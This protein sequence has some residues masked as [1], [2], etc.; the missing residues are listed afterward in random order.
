MKLWENKYK[1]ELDSLADQLNKS[2]TVDARL[3]FYDINGSLAHSR[4]LFEQGIISESD[5]GDIKSGLEEIRD[6]LE[7]G[8]LQIDYSA[9]DVHSFVEHELT[10]RKGDA[11]KKL[12]TGRSRNDQ[13][14]VDMRLYCKAANKDIVNLLKDLIT[15]IVEKSKENV[16]SIMPGYTH[17]QIAQP[18]TFAHYMLSYA[19]MF[20]RDIKRLSNAYDIMDENPL[21]SGALST[22]TYPI[23][24]FKTTEYLGFKKPT[25]NSM[26]SVSDRDY[27]LETAFDI[28]VTAM[29]L[30]RFAEEIV[31][32]SSSEFRYIRL[33][34]KFTTGSSIMPQKKNPDMAELIRGK[35]GR[36]YGN[37]TGLLTMMKA[38]PMTYAKDMQEDKQMLFDS[39]DTIMLSIK[40]FAGMISTMTVDKK[41]M[42][43]NALNGFINATDLADY[44]TKKGMPFRDAY[45]ITG[46]IVHDMASSGKK[47][48]EMSIDE[49]KCYSGIFEKDLYEAI[50]LKNI[51]DKRRVYG[52]A[53]SEFVQIQID[54]IENALKNI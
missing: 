9:E 5:Y 1:G 51:V 28:A 42:S 13:V 30:S 10:K 6:D 32:Y 48:S 47:L 18:V 25:E 34:D 33:S 37:L 17:M 2:I 46:E 41:R 19:Q 53:Q 15:V 24:R 44:L 27:I 8:K 49:Y 12:H 26:D 16:D 43:E 52:S 40:V 36:C 31:L 21:G 22:T 45:R 7:S 50:D 14:A 39:I 38:L 35:T 23:D 11:G 54:N 20:L 4:M 3:V 29:H